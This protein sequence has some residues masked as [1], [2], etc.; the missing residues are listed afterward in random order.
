MDPDDRLGRF[1]RGTVS[2][3]TY[4]ATG[5][6]GLLKIARLPEDPHAAFLMLSRL[7][8]DDGA[9]YVFPSSEAAETFAL[10]HPRAAAAW[11]SDID[12]QLAFGGSMLPKLGAP[13]HVFNQRDAV[14]AILVRKFP[15]LL[16]LVRREMQAL[17]TTWQTVTRPLAP[18]TS[19][20]PRG[21]HRRQP[22]TAARRAAGIRSGNDPGAGAD[23]DP[24][25]AAD[26]L[27]AAR[28]RARAA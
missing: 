22:R 5:Q 6:H 9:L 10:I 4:D 21:A 23:G 7:N 24:P 16:E 14:L 28:P 12:K 3:G 19:R 1:A 26:R 11:F 27:V 20:M 2:V 17:V 8:A 18:R 25:P 13:G 15:H